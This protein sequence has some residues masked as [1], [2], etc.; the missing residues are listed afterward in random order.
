ML[1]T[2][3]NRRHYPPDTDGTRTRRRITNGTD[4]PIFT[5]G[6]HTTILTIHTSPGPQQA[7]S[8]APTSQ[9]R[10]LPAS[11]PNSLTSLIDAFSPPNRSRRSAQRESAQQIPDRPAIRRQPRYN[12]RM[13]RISKMRTAS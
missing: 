4:P 13:P 10:R 7:Q 6:M 1:K 9:C 3:N 8:S 12:Q 2:K 5:Q 11:A